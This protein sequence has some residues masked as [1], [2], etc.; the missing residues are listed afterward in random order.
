MKTYR[1]KPKNSHAVCVLG[2]WLRN[3]NVPYSIQY[4]SDCDIIVQG[5]TCDIKIC[6]FA[7]IL[8]GN[9]HDI[10]IMASDITGKD[11]TLAFRNFHYITEAAGYGSPIP[12]D[13]GAGLNKKPIY[14]EDFELVAMR[15]TQFRTAP[16]PKPEHLKG[17]RP[18]VENTA[19]SFLRNNQAICTINLL[20][21]DDLL[22][23][24]MTWTINYIG[25]WE[26]PYPSYS[27]ENPA[28]LRAYLQQCFVEFRG[29]LLKKSKNC[30]P[31][32]ATI[33]AVGQMPIVL[34]PYE[35]ELD[36]TEPP[37]ED[38]KDV[39]ARRKNADIL[40]SHYLADL[41]HDRML[42]LLT[43]A[44]ENLEIDPDAADEAYKRLLKHQKTCGICLPLQMV[45][46]LTSKSSGSLNK[47]I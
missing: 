46:D 1:V 5:L 47:E 38:P 11:R 20:E 8:P 17:Y 28:K 37:E 39:L 29:L 45:V 40:L 9:T 2:S 31:S 36:I 35:E 6:V 22:T 33:E 4:E 25:H 23:Y 24:A 18:I 26:I 16:N 7:G 41:P 30:H 13:R 12:V 15:H 42:E 19:S 34:S 14:H 3:C 32:K 27:N 44:S 10:T 21:L 43:E